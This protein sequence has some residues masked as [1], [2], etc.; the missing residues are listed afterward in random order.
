[1]DDGD[2][3]GYKNLNDGDYEGYET[4]DDGEA[5]GIKH[6]GYKREDVVPIYMVLEGEMMNQKMKRKI[7]MSRWDVKEGVSKHKYLNRAS[8]ALNL[9]AGKTFTDF[10]TRYFSM[11]RPGYKMVSWMK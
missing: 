4:L 3:D 1:M 2:Y 5:M 6:Q 9:P 11:S 7:T 10:Y 8:E